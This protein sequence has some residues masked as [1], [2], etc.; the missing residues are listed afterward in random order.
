IP[1]VVLRPTM[2]YGE[3]G[4]LHF[5]RLT[6]LVKQA[7]GIFPVFGP[8]TAKLQPVHVRDV[9]RA[10]E[11]ALAHEGALSGT[12]GVSGGTVL[13]FAAL[14]RAIAHSLGVRR[15]LLHVPLS[16]SYAAA[17]I[18][19]RLSPTFFLTP[20]ALEGLNQDADLDHAPFAAACGYAPRALADG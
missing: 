9:A 19:V 10:V 15:R 14:V 1:W 18:A 17:R 4:G 6:A 13:T 5:A 7:P 3:G 16:L 11:L 2:V 20:E 8:G 12:W